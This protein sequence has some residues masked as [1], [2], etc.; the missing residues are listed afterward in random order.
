VTSSRVSIV[1]DHKTRGD[2]RP[3]CS[4]DLLFKTLDSIVVYCGYSLSGEHILELESAINK[5]L[6]CMLTG[7]F[8][9]KLV[10][11]RK[12]QRS[13]CEILREDTR[14]QV[15]V[16]TLASNFIQHC[17]RDGVL[18]GSIPVL[19]RCCENA[20]NNPPT[21]YEATRIL[22]LLDIMLMPTAIA[23]PLTTLQVTVQ[24][25]I[26]RAQRN[27]N[28]EVQLPI[29]NGQTVD[30]EIVFTE[31]PEIHDKIVIGDIKRKVRDTEEPN[32]PVKYTRIDNEIEIAQTRSKIEGM[33]G[34]SR[35]GGNLKSD[36]NPDETSDDESLPEI[37]M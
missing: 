5:A 7:V 17:H 35:P 10:H 15:R 33:F 30:Q 16:L 6:L 20:F 9:G 36:A 21:R 37:N 1:S 19:K 32:E 12:I 29:E 14:L 34:A 11:N 26:S 24:N 28:A 23:I 8:P 2:R 4:P 22:S 31:P 25:E 13:N 3:I 27:V 18:C